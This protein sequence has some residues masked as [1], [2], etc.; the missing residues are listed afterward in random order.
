MVS[1]GEGRNDEGEDDIPRLSAH[2]LAALSEFYAEQENHQGGTVD[3]N[4]QLS[5][6]WYSKE[7]AQKLAEECISAVSEGGCIA[8]ISCPTLMEYLII[9]EKIVS[10]RI[11]VKLFEFDDRFAS[12][13]AKNFIKYDY[14]QPLEIPPE[15]KG[16]Y[17][18]IIADPPFLADECLV[19][20]AQTVRLLSK[21][22][23]S[24]GQ[25]NTKT[26]ICT[27]AIMQEMVERIFSAHQCTFK[28]THQNNLANEF[29]CFAN[30]NTQI[31]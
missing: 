7:T 16:G 27:G 13:Y 26:I 30:Y 11:S 23:A 12:K 15:H 24:K 19:K 5:Q 2:T 6:F 21:G 4:W 17:D 25:A 31:L 3:E 8:C 28:P 14:R 20:V 10:G 9:N 22:Q 18:L 29:A 1:S